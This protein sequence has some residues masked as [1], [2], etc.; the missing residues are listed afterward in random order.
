M[1]YLLLA[2]GRV[3]LVGWRKCE[4]RS[5]EKKGIYSPSLQTLR[6][7]SSRLRSLCPD[8]LRSPSSSRCNTVAW[9]VFC[10]YNTVDCVG[11]TET[12]FERTIFLGFGSFFG[13][14]L[15]EPFPGADFLEVDFLFEVPWVPVVSVKAMAGVGSEV[16]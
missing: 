14:A 3:F 5:V 7:P 2:Q 13:A 11:A 15:R 1:T 9:D 8:F 6:V 16:D 4:I 10:Y 12:Y